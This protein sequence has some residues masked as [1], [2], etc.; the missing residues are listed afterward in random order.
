MRANQ[1]IMNCS[2]FLCLVLAFVACRNTFVSHKE[3]QT[4][5]QITNSCALDT[6]AYNLSLNSITNNLIGLPYSQVNRTDCSGIIYKV[7]QQFKGNCAEAVIPNIQEYRSSADLAYFLTKQ[8]LFIPCDKLTGVDE[9][10]IG[11]TMFYGYKREKINHIALVVNVERNDTGKAISYTVFHGRKPGIPASLTTI[12][13]KDKTEN[14]ANALALWNQE[15]IGHGF[16][17]DFIQ[18]H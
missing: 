3:P 8:N 4:N 17:E 11:A 12:Q 10:R 5:I 14:Y 7:L 9:L 13:I 6:S 15:F 1:L 18:S 2:N 16:I